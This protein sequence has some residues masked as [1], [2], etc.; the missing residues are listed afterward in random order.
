MNY[1]VKLLRLS[2]GLNPKPVEKNLIILLILFE[3]IFNLI[4]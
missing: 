2:G 4:G 1:K 3:G